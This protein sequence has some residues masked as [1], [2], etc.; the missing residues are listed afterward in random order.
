MASGTSRGPRMVAAAGGEAGMIR[1]AVV[2]LGWWG[3]QIARSLAGSDAVRVVR[4]VD[5]DRA[6]HGGFAR[7]HGLPLGATLDEVLADPAVEAV[8]LCT[9]QAL[10]TGQVLAAARAGKHVF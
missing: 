7:E 9:P 8:I 4:A 3:R 1:A 2:G 5:P 10:H 6:A